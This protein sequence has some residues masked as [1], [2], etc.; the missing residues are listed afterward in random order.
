[1]ASEKRKWIIVWLL[2]GVFMILMQVFIGGITRLTGSGLS[3][4]KW[5]IITGT[6]PPLNEMSWQKAFD[7]YKE[8]PQYHKINK[9]FSL[10]D[11]KFIFFWEYIHRLW[12]R[13]MGFVFLIPCMY[14]WFSGKFSKKLKLRLVKVFLLAVLVAAFGWI[15]VASGLIERPWVN[16]YK[17]SFHLSLALILFLYLVYVVSLEIFQERR[18]VEFKQVYSFYFIL[19][20]LLFLQIFIGGMMA[21]MKAALIYPTWPKIGTE[22]FPS[23]ILDNKNWVAFNF[24]HYD[25]NLFFPAL[26]QW[27]HRSLAYIILIMGI[28]G[29]IF[30]LRKFELKGSL[31]NLLIIFCG[32]LCVQVLLGIFTLLYSIGSVPIWFGVFHQLCG[33]LTIATCMITMINSKYTN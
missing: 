6:L 10:D 11:F 30:Y 25:K 5:D 28:S 8:T 14:F 16:A 33:F 27:L 29:S 23:L 2:I 3:I 17:L 19:G 32:L 26:V 15:M 7:L 9:G 31:R 21:G 24:E 12:A 22:Y 4:T 1:M 20:F 18:K 13:L